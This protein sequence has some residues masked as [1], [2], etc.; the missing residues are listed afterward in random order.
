[1]I[2]LLQMLLY[3]VTD[4]HIFYAKNYIR[5]LVKVRPMLLQVGIIILH[6]N[7]RLL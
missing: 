3:M 7:V 6:D 2:V 5:K 1:M 4:T